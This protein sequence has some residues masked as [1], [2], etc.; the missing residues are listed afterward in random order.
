MNNESAKKSNVSPFNLKT[1]HAVK[2]EPLKRI[3][4]ISIAFIGG[5]GCV[6]TSPL[7]LLGGSIGLITGMITQ[8][9]LFESGFQGAKIGSL[10]SIYTMLLGIELANGEG[11]PAENIQ[12]KV[13]LLTEQPIAETH[14]DQTLTITLLPTVIEQTNQSEAIANTTVESSDK[15][16]VKIP[17]TSEHDIPAPNLNQTSINASLSVVVTEQTHEP[18]PI[19]R[20]VLFFPSINRSISELYKS[21]Q[22]VN[23]N[24]HEEITAFIEKVNE[25]VIHNE[26]KAPPKKE[27]NLATVSEL[28][29]HKLIAITTTSLSSDYDFWGRLE[30]LSDQD[31]KS[32]VGKLNTDKEKGVRSSSE[33]DYLWRRFKGVEFELSKQDERRDKFARVLG[34]LS[35]VQLKAAFHSP[36]FLNILNQDVYIQTAANTLTSEQLKLFATSNPKHDILNIMI[37]KLKPNNFL[38][39]KLTAIMPYATET[40]KAAL[41][42]QLSHLPYPASFKIELTKLAEYYI[43]IN[44]Q[45]RRMTRKSDTELP[46]L[47]RDESTFSI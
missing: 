44:K 45:L 43:D 11:E 35:E 31:I 39:G 24:K 15:T 34:T 22:P 18:E 36:D 17:L 19:V 30:Q 12:E 10:G 26:A 42:D 23:F 7:L 13:H 9:N 32:F 40:V 16:Q 29:I 14:S 1:E 33:L 27:E 21:T 47:N 38:L 41:I 8:T 28:Y 5:I 2:P 37:K 25:L 4:G 3:A 46:A 6:V 20:P